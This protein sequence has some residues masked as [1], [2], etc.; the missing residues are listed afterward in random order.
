MCRLYCNFLILFL[1]QLQLFAPLLHAHVDD[2]SLQGGLHLPGLEFQALALSEIS[3]QAPD[4]STHFNHL[5][6]S[7]DNGFQDKRA[8][9]AVALEKPVVC[10]ASLS[11]PPPAIVI[12]DWHFSRQSPPAYSSTLGSPFSPRAPPLIFPAV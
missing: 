5:V 3:L 2:H 1:L 12:T 8:A 10:S 4:S 7:I 9:L 6:V 11:S